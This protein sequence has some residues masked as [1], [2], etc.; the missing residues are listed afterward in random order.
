VWLNGGGLDWVSVES[1]EF[2]GGLMTCVAVL[3]GSV[4]A[5]GV[6]YLPGDLGDAAVWVSS[7]GRDWA[8]VHSEA[9]GGTEFQEMLSRLVTTVRSVRWMRRCG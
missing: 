5:V 3:D 6:G 8:R 4:I 1:A 9:F 7:D 2:A